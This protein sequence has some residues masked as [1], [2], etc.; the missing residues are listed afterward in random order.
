MNHKGYK[1]GSIKERYDIFYK[2]RRIQENKSSHSI[3]P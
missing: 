2:K 1:A 3:P